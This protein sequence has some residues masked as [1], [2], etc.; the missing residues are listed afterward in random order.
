[1]YLSV[2]NINNILVAS[3]L[4][5]SFNFHNRTKNPACLFSAT[6][7]SE[8]NSAAKMAAPIR[9]KCWSGENEG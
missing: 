2:N 4:I 9:T 8:L 3:D 5:N 1:M 7:W 6:C